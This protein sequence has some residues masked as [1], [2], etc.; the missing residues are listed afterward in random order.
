LLTGQDLQ[1]DS[2][3]IN[4]K[5]YNITIFTIETNQVVGGVIL[6]VTDT[7]MHREQIAQRAKQV[8]RKNLET[9]QEIAFRLGENMAD[10]EILL[11]SLA[12]GFSSKDIN[13]LEEMESQSD[14]SFEAQAGGC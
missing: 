10:T 1:R 6:D 9:V 11:R 5:I 14:D 2:L 12:Y 4:N 3:H 8:I 13:L 7:E